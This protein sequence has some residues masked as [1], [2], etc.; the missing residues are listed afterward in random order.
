MRGWQRGQLY[1]GAGDDG[2][3]GDVDAEADNDDDDGDDDDDDC[4]VFTSSDFLVLSREIQLGLWLASHLPG[5]LGII[6]DHIIYSIFPPYHHYIQP[7]INKGQF[8]H[9]QNADLL[10]VELHRCVASSKRVVARGLVWDLYLHFKINVNFECIWIKKE[11][12]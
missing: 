11:S 4:D 5:Q 8:P 2:D 7:T 12:K 1:Q 10:V 6:I 9:H 3:D